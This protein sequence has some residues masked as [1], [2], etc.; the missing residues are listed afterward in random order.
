MDT[1][2]CVLFLISLI[3]KG[4]TIEEDTIVG[5]VSWGVGCAYLPGVFSRVSRASD[6]I[7]DKVPELAATPEPT[8]QPTNQPTNSKFDG[9]C[10][11]FLFGESWYYG[12]CVSQLSYFSFC[13]QLRAN[14]STNQSTYKK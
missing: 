1:T 5:V 7:L 3:M 4:E 10:G 9:M 13:I 6:W 12:N 8:N 2:D 14:Q 11:Q